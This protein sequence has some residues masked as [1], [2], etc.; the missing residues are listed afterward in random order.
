VNRVAA[1]QIIVGE[2]RAIA[3]RIIGPEGYSNNTLHTISAELRDAADAIDAEI[4]LRRPPFKD[5][6]V[7]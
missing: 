3:E 6:G 7:A 4:V 1:I 5:G 2:I